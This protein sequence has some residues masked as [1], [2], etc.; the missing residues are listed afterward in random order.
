MAKL[1]LTLHNAVF[2]KKST[3]KETT[4]GDIVLST[5]QDVSSV[6]LYIDLTEKEDST[7]KVGY[8]ISMVDFRFQKKMY[9][10]T[11][12][13]ATLQLSK[14]QGDVSAWRPVPRKTLEN[15]FSHLRVSLDEISASEGTVAT[16]AKPSA[17][18]DS[19]S[20]DSSNDAAE[21]EIT[22]KAAVSSW[23]AP[24]DALGDDFYVHEIVTRYK[25][26]AMY[27]TLKI[28]S[29]DKLL[30]LKTASRAFVSKKLC[31]EILK[32]EMPKYKNPWDIKAASQTPGALSYSTDK[33]R[34]L[35]YSS[36][37]EHIFPYLVQYNE[38][39]YDMIA[40][41]ANRW[42]EFLY[43]E[44]GTLNVGYDSGAKA[45]ALKGWQDITYCDESNST[46]TIA[47][48]GMEAAEAAYDKDMLNNPLKR[49]PVEVKG[50][51]GCDFDHG[52][53]GW[54]IKQFSSFFAN[55]DNLP[56][57]LGKTAFN[58]AYAQFET[59]LLT[60]QKN[61]RIDETWF[62][63]TT[64]HHGKLK[65]GE[66]ERDAYNPFSEFNSVY[67][68][69]KYQGI[70]QN[71]KTAAQSAVRIAFDTANPRVRLG[72]PVSVEE[73][74]Y[75]VVEVGAATKR[76]VSYSLDENNKVIPVEA[77][78]LVFEVVALPEV[79][80]Q[81][82]PAPLPSGHIRLSGPQTAVVAD[83]DDP[84]ENNRVRVL[85][86]WQ[87][88][89]DGDKYTHAEEASPWLIYASSGAGNK[90]GIHSRHHKDDRVLVAFAHGNVERPF[91]VGGLTADGNNVPTE[92]NGLKFVQQMALV[93]P[94]LH[95]LKLNDGSGAGLTAFIG[96]LFSPLYGVLSTLIPGL[97]G[98]D[99]FSGLKSSARFEGGFELGDKYGMYNISGSTDG[100]NVSIK[101]PWGDVAINA[102][103]G[104]TISAPNGDVNITGKNVKIQA[105]NNLQLVSGT[106][107]DYKFVNRTGVRKKTAAAFALDAAT[108]VMKKLAAKL[109]VID[110]TLIRDVVEVVMRPVEGALT[111]KSNRFLKLESGK[112]KADYPLPDLYLDGEARKQKK[113]EAQKNE[114]RAGLK[115]Q[116]G[117][118]E[119]IDMLRCL[120]STINAEYIRLYNNCYDRLN[121]ATGF[122]TKIAHPNYT[123]LTDDNGKICKT[124]DELKDKFWGDAK[125]LTEADLGFEKGFA[126]DSDLS[127][128]TACLRRNGAAS[129]YDIPDKR[130]EIISKRKKARAAILNAANELHR[131]ILEFKKFE[132]GKTK[133]QIVAMMPKMT[134]DAPK[135]YDLLM[136]KAFD[137]SKL[138]DIVYFKPA[139]DTVKSLALRKGINDMDGTMKILRR[140]AALLLLDGLGFKDEWRSNGADGSP[141]N[142]PASDADYE[143]KWGDYVGTIVSLPK[144]SAKENALA[145]AALESLGSLIDM[146]NI[147]DMK[148]AFKERNSWADAKK[149]SILFT[150]G[151]KTYQLGSTISVADVPAKENLTAADDTADDHSVADFLAVLRVALNQL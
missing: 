52:A 132:K 59:R 134:H 69:K 95:F 42:G 136:A 111:V 83:S 92:L 56:T 51:L 78:A 10:P 30:T 54:I 29:P 47:P 105:G 130:K 7:N 86:P 19:S 3:D 119:L 88:A 16:V 85:F 8:Q 117:T 104:I 6:F 2:Y 46:L 112:G 26:T 4:K 129:A 50:V 114:L 97:S 66:K 113:A 123:G 70:L 64:E 43:Y 102:F 28:Y 103:T 58:E 45:V 150:S 126:I 93:T 31:D 60:D 12:I 55:S 139:D 140:K 75:I 100:R 13:V 21:K 5:E 98:K 110:L 44:G 142:R 120:A 91:V 131:A 94:G 39:F 138:G 121:G 144:L 41:T 71:E 146:K 80:G 18:E 74:P 79:G 67:D 99:I 27:V 73:M 68:D 72:Q 77:S 125:K 107:V 151:G 148:T 38:S 143:T 96:G 57:F 61:S 122:A 133:E 89:K 1:Q 65:I 24:V 49:N 48:E 137:K 76:T 141:V 118:V 116:M 128:S 115:L 106:N 82:Y 33:L 127:P 15:L 124:Y 87:D 62:K 14:L 22:A 23:K 81:F 25:P 11:E 37:N 40:R 53:D 145:K 90:N 35:R 109:Q 147:M 63:D 149:G 34:V 9:Q 108:A 32:T 20:K 17:S 84:L 135:D 36:G 101:S